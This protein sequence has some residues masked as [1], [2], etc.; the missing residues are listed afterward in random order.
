MNVFNPVDWFELPV[1]NMSRAKTFYETVLDIQL[2][3]LDLP[4][5][6]FEM[7]TFPMAMDEPN[8]SGALV[9]GASYEPSM[10]G[11]I[12][13]FHCADL[14]VE[15][16]RVKEAGGEILRPK[17]SIGEFGFVA[18]IKDTEGNRVGLHTS[19]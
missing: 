10:T 3:K 19:L 4:A 18:I 13:Y 16:D 7:W 15:L 17:M 11:I 8:A 1:K 5:E 14:T 9:Q 2:N 12:L 6:D